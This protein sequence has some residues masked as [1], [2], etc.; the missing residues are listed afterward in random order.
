MHILVDM[1]C[2]FYTKTMKR[3]LNSRTYLLPN[4]CNPAK[5]DGVILICRDPRADLCMHCHIAIQ[6]Q[7]NNLERPRPPPGGAH[8][9]AS[10]SEPRCDTRRPFHRVLPCLTSWRPTPGTS[11]KG[12]CPTPGPPRPPSFLRR[13]FPRASAITTR[14]IGFLNTITLPASDC[15]LFVCLLLN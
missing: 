5:M 13:A 9:P 15:C 10:A 6:Q 8:L 4:W 12:V 3:S 7:Y 2:H 14:E 11:S 1:F